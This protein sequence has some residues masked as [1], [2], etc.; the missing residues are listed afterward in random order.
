MRSKLCAPNSFKNT[1]KFCV[2]PNMSVIEAKVELTKF[3]NFFSFGPEMDI[4]P[5]EVS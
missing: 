2:R 4:Y 5:H 1:S 3:Q